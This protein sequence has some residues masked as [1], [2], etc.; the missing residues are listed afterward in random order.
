MKKKTD[1]LDCEKSYWELMKEQEDM[2]SK[3]IYWIYNKRKNKKGVR[4]NE[5]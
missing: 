4:K 3:F 1:K 2:M 5:R